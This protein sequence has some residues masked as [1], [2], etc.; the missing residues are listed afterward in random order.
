MGSAALR[1]TGG[2]EGHVVAQ[3]SQA[4]LGFTTVQIPALSRMDFADEE[5]R[6]SFDALPTG[7]WS[8]TLTR[9]GYRT[10]VRSD[11]V[12]R[13]GRTTS[14]TVAMTEAPLAQPEV[15]I[16]ADFIRPGG[17]TTTAFALDQDEIRRA[18]G[19]IEDL[20]RLVQSLPAVT[21]GNDE[22]NDIIARGG[23][24]SENLIR[25]DGLEVPYLNHFA[26]QGSSGGALGMVGSELVQDV[27]FLAG[28]FPRQYGDRVSSVL[29]VKLREGGRTTPHAELGVNLAG[30]SALLEGP[31][32]GGDPADRRG[33]WLV[34]VRQSYF[35]LLQEPFDIPTV[36]QTTS[37]L[38]KSVWEPAPSDRIELLSL[39]GRDEIDFRADPRDLDDPANEDSRQ[40]GARSTTG[41]TWRH[42]HGDRGFVI[43]TAQDSEA[44]F[45]SDVEDL[46][47]DG[48]T[49]FRDR[50]RTGTTT[51]RYDLTWKLREL[52][53]RAGAAADRA[54][55]DYALDQ[56]VGVESPYSADSSRVDAVRHRAEGT[57]WRYGTYA[58][59]D[60]PLLPRRELRG[61]IGGRVDRYDVPD[62]DTFGPRAA[63][64][65]Q[66]RP[67]VE[68]SAA[69]G[70]YH[71]EPDLVYVTAAPEN[72]SLRPIRAD[73]TV[74]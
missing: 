13:A 44:R 21:I 6:F 58:E 11:V 46:D 23:S 65:W 63:I 5:G 28:A 54:R 36:P 64:S 15:T 29:D 33:S 24:P 3:E 60:F 1:E 2:L 8:L 68:L 12:V 9:I 34:S 57:A 67:N 37:W 38:L 71:Q 26:S 56:P 55:F 52:H 61:T 43:V 50:S 30:A 25:V 66:V 49:I 62:V 19:A 41:I 35:D 32:P 74:V 40:S 20:S 45:E 39:G 47:L 59:V 48:E 31:L 16:N 7:T 72:Q 51:V 53:V 27:L 73:H 17:V 42:I 4:P 18:P 22:R 14:I 70:R 69:W 10:V